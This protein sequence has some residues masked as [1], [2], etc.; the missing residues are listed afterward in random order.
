MKSI[1]KYSLKP[2]SSA[3]IGCALVVGALAQNRMS[4]SVSGNF[5]QAPADPDDEP[6]PSSSCSG[7]AW[8]C[9]SWTCR[10]TAAT[11]DRNEIGP[12]LFGDIAVM[13]TSE[14]LSAHRID[15]AEQYFT[16]A[17]DHGYWFHP[18]EVISKGSVSA[19]A[20]R[21][22]SWPFEFNNVLVRPSGFEPPAFLLPRQRV[23]AKG[24]TVLRPGIWE[25]E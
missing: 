22:S 20:G 3:G 23:D 13:R 1:G 12:E 5:L 24:Q 2:I 11:G 8:A 19:K 7:T 6:T 15:G 9:G 10:T 17:I 21:R 14:L 16:R 25:E 4:F 18:E